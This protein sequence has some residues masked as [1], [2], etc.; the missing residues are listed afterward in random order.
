MALTFERRRQPAIA[1][2]LQTQALP[3][4]LIRAH[5]TPTHPI[6]ALAR[7]QFHDIFQDT[8]LLG[9]D[10]LRLPAFT[11]LALSALS[12]RLTTA[13]S[14]PV[15]RASSVAS[16]SGTVL[17]SLARRPLAGAIVQIALADG[18][19]S[20]NR[21]TNADTLGR[22]LI[23]S[24]PAGRYMLGFFHP[25]LDSLG[26]EPPLR[27]LIVTGGRM[28]LADLAI[29][30]AESFRKSICGARTS[31]G[32][33]S[34]A[35]ALVV[36]IV[37]N[38]NDLSAVTDASVAVEWLE[39]SF[40]SSGIARRVPKLLAKSAANG[41][42]ALCNVPSTGA[43]TLSAVRGADSTD[44][45]EFEMMP[46]G[47][48]RRDLYL[49]HATTA[50][51]LAGTRLSGTIVAVDGA[52]PVAGAEVSLSETSKTRANERGEWTLS[53]AAP[54]TH[55]LDIR[56]V[57]FYPVRRAVDVVEGAPPVH[58]TLATLKSV[59][60][61][62]RVTAPRTFMSNMKDF[63][64]RRKT[65]IGQFITA[66]DLARKQPVVVSD[67]FRFIPGMTLWTERDTMV[68]RVQ[69]RRGAFDAPCYPDTFLDGKA[70]GVLTVD[71]L[72]NLVLVKE[73]RG[74]E[75][76]VGSNVPVQF[77]AGTLGNACGS[78]LIWTKFG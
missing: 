13:Q 22:F 67:V 45:L 38:A 74:I 44:R 9:V 46:G 24:V 52:R 70:L 69:F 30:S 39:L 66:A 25:M 53:D 11:L 27:E 18:A 50:Q 56:A 29:P 71:Q 3:M 37:R 21:T 51:V 32:A 42:Y 48:L 75:I 59:L 68:T 77:S 20:V 17:D 1:L 4:S 62:V 23:D 14:A 10:R 15:A 35:G 31:T 78:I 19:T 57:G 34:A 55:M 49:A 40:T 60:G 16:V 33:N 72:D 2:T 64:F 63:E 12:G 76:Y 73:V 7:F 6:F 47:F 36:G 61:A 41:W 54:G 58:V 65:G 8:P 28:V 5:L 26:I 43:V